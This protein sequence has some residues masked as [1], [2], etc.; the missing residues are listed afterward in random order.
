MSYINLVD[1]ETGANK[2]IGLDFHRHYVYADSAM[3]V[4]LGRVSAASSLL[5]IIDSEFGMEQRLSL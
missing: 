5:T 2:R 3:L 1:E 4:L